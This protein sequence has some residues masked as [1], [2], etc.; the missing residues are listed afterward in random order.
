MEELRTIYTY[1]E[2]KNA[3][4]QE[5][6]S[7]AVSFVR[8]GYLLKQ[9]RDTD[10][11]AESE[12]GSMEEFA[13]MEFQL[14]KSQ[15]SRFIN[16]NDRFSI[17]GNSEYLE[18]RYKNFG[19]AKLGIMLTLSNE[20]IE[21]L[22]P[23]LSKQQISQIQ[24]EVKEEEKITDIE[25]MLEEKDEGQE[26]YEGLV[27]KI[28]YAYY[29]L[30]PVDFKKM[31]E[32][33]EWVPDEVIQAFCPMGVMASTVR[34]QGIGRFMISVRDTESN[35]AFTN[36]RTNESEESNWNQLIDVIFHIIKCN[37]N[38][39][40][41][42]TAAEDAW[43]TIYGEAYPKKEEPVHKVEKTAT[44]KEQPK[45][46][47]VAPVQQ[48]KDSKVATT[49]A[50]DEKAERLTEKDIEVETP[51]DQKIKPYLNNI[52]DMHLR[53]LQQCISE[54]KWKFAKT[55]AE[56]IKECLDKIIEIEENEAKIENQ[57]S[58]NDYLDNVEK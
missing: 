25:V 31:Y 19:V 43:E 32:L 39:N 41:A 8:I 2:Y 45:K 6:N 23:E 50:A 47:K 20:V 33:K 3:L 11:L 12:Y 58:I 35:I 1:N 55:Q 21:H 22:S 49:K 57:I 36:V 29:Q 15:V 44:P 46:E 18:D 26:Q 4:R 24:K 42:N 53:S 7:A 56:R 28:I 17:N 37:R 48:K 13:K 51:L 9:A 5:L 10:I 54:K 52:Q 34:I 40:Y 27:A 16:I 38:I 14:D 30:H